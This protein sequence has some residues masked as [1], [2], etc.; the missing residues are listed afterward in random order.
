M[1]ALGHVK[2]WAKLQMCRNDGDVP[3][4]VAG[5]IYFA[6]ILSA[7]VRFGE[8]LSQLDDERL[9]AAAVW[10]Q[11]QPWLDDELGELFRRAEAS[12]NSPTG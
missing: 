2:D 9:R 11:R 8:R 3:R 10:G 4:E 6:A 12:L 5:V 1:S 7:R